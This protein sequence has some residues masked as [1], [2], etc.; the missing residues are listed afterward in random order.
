MKLHKPIFFGCHNQSTIPMAINP[1]MHKQTKYMERECHFIRDYIKKNK[2]KLEFVKSQDQHANILTKVLPKSRFKEL[3]KKI[4]I[5]IRKE[6]K[7]VG[8]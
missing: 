2:A 4:R 1:V 8:K 5:M 3:R 6:F 7:I